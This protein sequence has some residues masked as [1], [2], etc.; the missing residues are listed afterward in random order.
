MNIDCKNGM[1]YLWVE[2]KTKTHNGVHF[3]Y[4]CKVDGCNHTEFKLFERLKSAPVISR[5]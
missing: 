4:R 5:C 1:H 3:S 2:R